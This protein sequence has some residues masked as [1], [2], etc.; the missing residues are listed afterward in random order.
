MPY[1]LKRIDTETSEVNIYAGTV[2]IGSRDDCDLVVKSEYVLPVHAELY[3]QMPEYRLAASHSAFIEINNKEVLKWPAVLQDDD[4]ITLGDVKFRFSII[5]EVIPR[6]KKAAFS[7]YLAG[8]LLVL[9]LAAEFLIMLWLPYELRKS[10]TL[11]LATARQYACRQIDIVRG[12][13]RG[14]KVPDNNK[15]IARLKQLVLSS[16]NELASYL[17][18]YGRRMSLDQTITVRSNL[19]KMNYIVRL[20]PE[21]CEDYKNNAVLDAEKYVKSLL[22]MLS[23]TMDKKIIERYNKNEIYGQT[24]GGRNT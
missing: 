22:E 19:N 3:R 20:W 14:L 10:K 15:D 21:F 17:R 8:A 7:S 1:V 13:T 24:Q 23:R 4:I 18:K 5:R 12:R 6:S 11:S 2:K 16:E 9:L